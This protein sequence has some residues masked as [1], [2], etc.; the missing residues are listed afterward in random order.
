MTLCNSFG[1]NMLRRRNYRV[2]CNPA[3]GG[4]TIARRCRALR[5]QARGDPRQ[6]SLPETERARGLSESG[7]VQEQLPSAWLIRAQKRAPLTSCTCC[8]AA[9]V[10]DAW[11]AARHSVPSFAQPPRSELARRG[12]PNRKR[13]DPRA[14]AESVRLTFRRGKLPSVPARVPCTPA[15][16]QRP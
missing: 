2:M 12:A 10:R 14:A 15:R 8:A 13:A 1:N 5:P 11:P 3:A 9:T 6:E 4:K 16:S 7:L